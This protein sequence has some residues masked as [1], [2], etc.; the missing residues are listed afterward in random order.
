V[1]DP[2]TGQII[3]GAVVVDGEWLSAIKRGYI[4]RVLTAQRARKS[5][6]GY[7][8]TRLLVGSEGTLGIITEVTV[9]LYGIPEKILAAVC[10]FATLEGACNAVIQSIQ[11]GLGV[12]RGDRVATAGR[13]VRYLTGTI[14]L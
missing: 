10:P 8:L 6:A 1:S 14:E 9:R 12:A 4:D 7:D 3:R 2:D 13:P 11:L 5:S